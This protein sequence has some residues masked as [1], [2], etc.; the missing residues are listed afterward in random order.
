[1]SAATGKP[2]SPSAGT[3]PKERVS[4]PGMDLDEA[5]QSRRKSQGASQKERRESL[6]EQLRV[7]KKPVEWASLRKDLTELVNE[8]KCYPILVRLSWHDAGT[9]CNSS[10]TGGAHAC[11]RFDS[12]GEAKHEANKGLQVAR[13]LLDPILKKYSE[14]QMLSCSDLWAYAA[15]VA[16]KAAGGP[17]IP[18]RYGRIDAKDAQESVPEGRLPDG[19]KGATHVREVFNRLG[20]D[21][22]EIVA[23]SGAHTLGG[24]HKDRSGFE[25]NWSEHPLKFDNSYFKDLFHKDWKEVTVEGTGKKEYKDARGLMMLMTDICLKEDPQFK[26]IAEKFAED[27]KAFFEKFA[28]AF[29]KLQELGYSENELKSIEG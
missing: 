17:D 25:G 20:F 29:Q 16:I 24:A 23:L 5:R 3:N 14:G 1:M 28:S 22:S 2:G 19:D 9:F 15:V 4:K 7:G 27:E 10:K 26:P 8:K 11:M 13:D 12:G 21:D 6:R 18:F